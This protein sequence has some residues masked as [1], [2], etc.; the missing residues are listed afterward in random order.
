MCLKNDNVSK[1]KT[2][3]VER[4]NTVKKKL[5]IT[6]AVLFLGMAW[7]AMPAEA[8][9]IPVIKNGSAVSLKG[10][11][12]NVRYS[13]EEV[14][15]ASSAQK[16][17]SVK[18]GSTI[19]VPC[20]T[21][22]SENGIRASYSA[23]GSKVTLRY[24]ARKVIFYANKKYAKVNGTK[25]KLKVSP[26][27][28][29]FRSRG[30]TDLLVPV[31]QA[32]SFFGLK[33]SYSDSARTVTLQVRPGISQTATK[34]KNVSKSSFI[35]EIGPVARENYKRT[36]ILA[37]V[38]MAQAILES[39]WGQS[40]LAKNGNN[41]FGMKMNLSGNTW[42]GSAWDGVNFYKK[43]TYEY[44]SGGRYS[45]T[46]KFRKYSCIEDS[47]EDHSAYLLNA[48]NGSRKRYAGFTKTSSY[49]K[50]LQIIKKGG[51]A[52]SGSYVSQL[53]GVIRTYNLT[54]WDK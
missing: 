25:M 39:G 52:T 31:N 6:L 38:T 15:V 40:T 13:G 29:T 36:G 43:R 33:Y 7:K 48:K 42:S 4:R 5:I 19:Y 54:K 11:I 3:F 37:S 12:I 18:I 21:L 26:Y 44:G 46:A 14:S 2:N 20:R 53:S 24:G 1:D 9:K 23:N 8:A 34:A 27:F 47:I 49:K 17:P 32:A 50:Q 22:F 41:L 16:A 28:V 10:T 51:Y 45:I 35:N 30:V